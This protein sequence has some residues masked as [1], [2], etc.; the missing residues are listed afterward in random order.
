M[1]DLDRSRRDV[2]LNGG[3]RLPAGTQTPPRRPP[4]GV[5]PGEEKD[6]KGL[7]SAQAVFRWYVVGGGGE[8]GWVG[9]WW[10]PLDPL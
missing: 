7:C 5:F 10:W 4:E 1:C 8:R 9:G 6:N 2:A 3:D